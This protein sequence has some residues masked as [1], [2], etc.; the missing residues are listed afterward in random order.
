MVHKQICFVNIK[1]SL[2]HHGRLSYPSVAIIS[3][4]ERRT[5]CNLYILIINAVCVLNL[6]F[7]SHETLLCCV[8]VSSQGFL[9]LL[10]TAFFFCW[11][12]CDSHEKLITV[13][14]H[15]CPSRPPLQISFSL[16]WSLSP[17]TFIYRAPSTNYIKM[18]QRWS[19]WQMADMISLPSFVAILTEMTKKPLSPRNRMLLHN[20]SE[21]ILYRPMMK[22]PLCTN[23]L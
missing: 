7:G 19:P 2:D 5:S 21:G 3:L 4:S 18:F 23:V 1:T 16:R 11:I 13:L 17:L 10:S 14:V 15:S 6:C 8:T 12:V 20:I 9:I 22:P